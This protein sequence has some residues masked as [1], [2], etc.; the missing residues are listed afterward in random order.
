ML[1]FAGYEM[2][3]TFLL[4]LVLSPAFSCNLF[5]L[6]FQLVIQKDQ[7][8]LFT[9]ITPAFIASSIVSN[10]FVLEPLSISFD[11]SAS[12]PDILAKTGT[13]IILFSYALMNAVA[14]VVVLTIPP[15]RFTSIPF[16]FF[17]LL[18]KVSASYTV[19]VVAP[20]PTSRKNAG[21]PP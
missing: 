15:Y 18:I 7:P 11:L 20:P 16:T 8:L 19:S 2:S 13:S 14:T 10:I 17:I 3:Q 4:F 9:S 21:L 12:A 5:H 1:A 6:L